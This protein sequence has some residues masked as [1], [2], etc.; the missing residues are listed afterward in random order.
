[1]EAVNMFSGGWIAA[2]FILFFICLMLPVFYLIYYVFKKNFNPLIMLVG[3]VAFVV[4]DRLAAS[5]LMR[6]FAPASAIGTISAQSY[7]IRRAL[8]IG[9]I[10]ALG[11]WVVLLLLSKRYI[12]VI[13]P[14]SFAL[15]YSALDMIFL[16]G[17]PGFSAFT[18]ATAINNNGLEEVVSTVDLAQQE[19][20]RQSIAELAKTPASNY[21]WRTGTA[22]CAF[23]ATVCIARLLWYS[24]EGGKAE[25][26]KILIPICVVAAVV[27]E[28]PA[29]LYAGGA[30]SSSVPADT[31]YYVMTALLVLG[32]ILVSRRHDEK[33]TVSDSRLR[34]RRR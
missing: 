16:K 5:L 32:T 18:Q 26:S 2:A 12:T 4:F 13:V 28:L 20:F 14:A 30:F 27:L 23:A 29:A 25:K 19:A 34:P 1:M 24:I 7:A 3:I 10:K 31:A 6:F 11:I 22:I 17:A 15:G 21:I 33:E 9:V 8:C